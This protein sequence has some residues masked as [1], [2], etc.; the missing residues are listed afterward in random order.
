[1]WSYNKQL[2]KTS[3]THVGTFIH[4]VYLNYL[5]VRLHRI[6]L[7]AVGDV[8]TQELL[9]ELEEVVETLPFTSLDRDLQTEISLALQPIR[10][11]NSQLRRRLRIANQQLRQIQLQAQAKESSQSGVS[12]EGW[13]CF[14][15]YITITS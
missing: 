6:D 8:Q 5:V 3:Q 11:E 15:C 14:L 9:T 2:K 7:I 13:Q 10:S 1:M 12:L 4:H